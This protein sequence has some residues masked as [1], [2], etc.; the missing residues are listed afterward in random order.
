[1]I[2]TDLMFVWTWD[3][4]PFPEF[5]LR[6]DI[7]GDAPKWRVGHWLSGKFPSLPPVAPSPAPSVGA[8]PTFPA[9]TGKGWSSIIRPKFATAVADH[10]SGK[11]SRAGRMRWPLYEIE[12]TYDFLRADA[13]SAE[14]QRIAGFFGEMQGQATPFWIAPPGLSALSNQIIV[15]GDGATLSFPLVRSIGDFTEPLAGVSNASA[16]RVASV[17]LPPNAWS[18]TGSYYPS[19]TLAAPPA[20]GAPVTVD[21]TALCLCRF[22]DD[23]LDL[24]QFVAML[25]KLR[26]VRLAPV[27]V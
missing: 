10:A 5:P 18:V 3:A 7:W 21:A 1:V 15:I 13:L 23:S 6:S 11:S 22:A 8:F 2:A 14:L 12:L 24:E 25:F 19:L 9:L 26:T 16:A 20:I 17:A 27:R 4:R